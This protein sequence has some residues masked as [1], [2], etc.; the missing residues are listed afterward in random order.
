MLGQVLDGILAETEEEKERGVC[1]GVLMFAALHQCTIDGGQWHNAW[2]LSRSQEFPSTEVN[3]PDQ[4]GGLGVTARFTPLISDDRRS[5]IAGFRKD[6]KALTE[7][8]SAPRKGTPPK[9][10]A[11]KKPSA[12]KLPGSQKKGN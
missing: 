7:S 4:D 5:V 3:H 6:M 1:L 10:P 9:S 2:E 8:T 12:G 11:N